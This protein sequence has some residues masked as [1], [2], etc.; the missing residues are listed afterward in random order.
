KLEVIDLKK[1]EIPKTEKPKGFFGGLYETAAKLGDQIE[2]AL[3]FDKDKHDNHEKAEALIIVEEATTP[4]KCKEI[5]SGQKDDGCIE[6][7]D[8]VCNELDAPKEE[9]ITTIQKKVKNDKLKSPEHSTSLATAINLAYL[10]KAAP[11]HEGLWRDKYNKAREYL[12]KQIG[13]KNAEEELIKCADD[14]VVENCTK[15]VIKDKKRNAVVTV[16]NSTTPEKCNDAVSK[17]ND[18]GSF[19]ISETICEDIDVPITEV[20]TTV[21]KDTQN[22]KLKSPESEPWWKTALALSYLKV[23]APH[24]EN[25]WKDKYNKAREYLSKQIGNPAAEQELLDC[26]DKYV[27]DNATKKVEKDHKKAAALPL[28]QD[29]ASPDKCKEI[30]SKQKDDGSIELDDSV[31]KELD[32]P[33]E[34]IITTI[35]KNITNK[36]LQLPQLPSLIPTAIN[37]SYLKNLAPHHEDVWKDKYDKAREYLS[38]QIGDKDAENEL[39]ECADKYVVDK[40][41][42]KVIEEKKRDVVDLK[43]DEI[44]ISEKPQDKSLLSTIP[45]TISN[46]ASGVID[47]IKNILPTGIG[48]KEPGQ[49]GEHVKGRSAFGETK[50]EDEPDK[51]GDHKK[52]FAPPGLSKDRKADVLASLQDAA[53]PD[54]CKDIVSK[55]KDDGSIELNDTVCNELD[56]PKEEIIT[57]IKKDIKNEKLQLPELPSLLSTAVNLSYLQNLAPKHKGHW[58]DHY[59][60]GREYISKKVGDADAEKELL[61]CTDKY[62]VDKAT[63]NVLDNKIQHYKTTQSLI[64]PKHIEDI[65]CDDKEPDQTEK[66]AAFNTTKE[67]VTPEV[68]EGITSTAN[69][70]GQIELNETLCKELDLPKEEIITT[71]Q[72]NIPNEKLK[73]PDLLSTA[74]ILSYLKNAAPKHEGQWKDKYNKAREYLSK[75]IGDP[76]AE[77]ELLD[78]TDNYV[79]DNCAKKAIKD[80][81]RSAVV[82]IQSSTTPDKHEA[83]VSKQKDDGSFELDDT[84]CKEL[85]VPVEN[86]VTGVKSCTNNKKLQTPESEPWW[87]TALTMSYLK[88]AAPHYENQWKDKYNK[89]R[90]YLSKQIGD[91]NVEEELLNCTNKYVVDRAHDKAIKYD[92]Q[93]PI[94]VTKLDFTDETY[95]QVLEGLRTFVDA[96]AARIICKSQNEDGSFTLNPLITE[97]LDIKPEEFIKS[98]KKYVGNLKLRGCDDSVW[99]TAFTIFYLKNVLKGHENEWRDA[100]DRASKWLSKK[101]DDPTLERELFSACKQYLVEQGSKRLYSKQIQDTEKIRILRLNVDDETRKIVLDD[102][103]TNGTEELA[104]TL[105]S[106]QESNGS[107]SPDALATLRP[108]IPSPESAVEHLKR[109][110]GSIK[111]RNSP[112]SIWHTAFVTYYLKNILGDHEKEWRHSHDRARALIT[113]QVDD[114]EAEKELY[115]ACEQYLLQQGIDLIN[116][117]GGIQEE[118]EEQVDVVVLQVS[119]ETRKAIHKSLREDVNEEVTRT[120]CNSQ[121]PNGSHTLHKSISDHLKIP[122][123]DNAVESLKRYVGSSFLRNCDPSLW[124]TALTTTYLRTVCDNYEQEWRPTCDRAA[125]WIT[126]QCKNPEAEK[127]LYSACDQ[128]LIKQGIDVLN[129]KNRQPRI[130]KRRSVVK[131]ETIQVITLKADDETRNA[132]YEFL[133]SQ[134]SP[135]HPRTI[136]TSQENEG[137]FTLHD[138]I[139]DHLQIPAGPVGEPIKR[140]V[141]S[142]VLRGCNASV[143][144]TA[145]TITYLNIVLNKYDSEWRPSCERAVKWVAEQVKDPEL[146]KELYSACEQYLFELGFELM[147][148]SGKAQTSKSV[149][150]SYIIPTRYGS[151]GG[152]LSPKDAYLNSEL[153]VV[154]AACTANRKLKQ[155]C[156]EAGQKI[157]KAQARER[158]IVFV[159]EEV[160]NLFTNNVTHSNKEDVLQRAKRAA[161]FLI[162]QYFDE[163]SD[164]YYIIPIRYGS[165]GGIT[166]TINIEN[167][168]NRKTIDM[169]KRYVTQKYAFTP[170][171][172]ISIKKHCDD[173]IEWIPFTDIEIKHIPIRKGDFSEIF[174]G[175][176]KPL[177]QDEAVENKELINIDIVLKVFKGSENFLKEF[178]INYQII[179]LLG[180]YAVP[181]YGLMIYPETN[182]YAMVMKHAIHVISGNLLIGLN[183]H[184]Q[185]E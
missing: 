38:T 92:I 183:S 130:T 6:L 24:H 73:S 179:Q 97:H 150:S 178:K 115:S 134:T 139:S 48:K 70:D 56:V 144:N 77:K 58:E 99:N 55:Q 62:V 80:K 4:E 143:W 82:H 42:G 86:I 8:S 151:D 101:I 51:K 152:I 114:A 181:F 169:D 168:D 46:T 14:Y 138:L 135:D 112:D 167:S 157:D 146:E 93:E 85:E 163:Y 41:T 36:K 104:R 23:A 120:I 153:I 90:E 21:K 166:S 33:K 159:E 65:I 154:G 12:S 68:C 145:F 125:A 175:K 22:E 174:I 83:A 30:V 111:L 20:V 156:T 121:E 133:R 87:K 10:K 131:G 155:S 52:A 49:E 35:Q 113:D 182:E 61:D 18:D 75:K 81:K 66:E 170:K 76:N 137:S 5:V 129:E 64:L 147:N 28:I 84:I 39:L 43:K 148:N 63:D 7:G 132:V 94:H 119:D 88:V 108:L 171:D 164:E 122:S 25:L 31:C 109:Y 78:F 127:E 149:D 158:I 136:L 103:R 3:T 29:A 128:Y 110:V 100:Y 126:E 173:F 11:H 95:Q 98:L 177:K 165:D 96:N 60:K 69:D 54:H 161:H 26:T 141:R 17:Q 185:R 59:N 19:E 79:V 71:V 37:I 180:E 53:S 142:P 13:D 40:A 1:D 72:N 117:R 74:V 160:S 116:S 176:W 15:K 123:I 45:E 16:Q 9:I 89:A 172:T 118:D 105:C 107:Y 184:G 67:S 106:A 162:D 44:P 27:V 2:N 57:S 50:I 102:L 47:T 124:N 91:P 140:Y 32:T 34:N